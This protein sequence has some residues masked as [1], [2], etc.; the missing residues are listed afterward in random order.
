MYIYIYPE[1]YSRPW[2]NR[3]AA[4]AGGNA[5]RELNLEFIGLSINSAL[6]FRRFDKV[7]PEAC[8]KYPSCTWRVATDCICA[9]TILLS[10]KDLILREECAILDLTVSENIQFDA[11]ANLV[12]KNNREV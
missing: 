9:D 3:Q 6:I 1:L 7:D 8:A 11:E 5:I 12:G 10:D 2:A 4:T